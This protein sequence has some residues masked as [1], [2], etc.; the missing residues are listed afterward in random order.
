MWKTDYS[1]VSEVFVT[2]CTSA[3]VAITGVT[4]SNITVKIKKPS[5]TWT[6]K[7]MQAS[8]WREVGSGLYYL[9]LS[10]S[11]TDTYGNLGYLVTHASGYFCAFVNVTD[12]ATEAAL[13]QNIYDRMATKVN[14]TDILTREKALDQQIE[15]LADQVSGFSDD[16]ATI[17][18]ALVT[19]RRRISEL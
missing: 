4:Y 15:A 10:A 3:G 1:A 19:L 11:D 6:T 16:L 13:L 14:K 5:G 8:Y 18:A 17:N 2:L 9:T 7:T 12:Y